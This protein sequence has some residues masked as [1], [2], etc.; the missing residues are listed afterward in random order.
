MLTY[1]IK[2]LGGP[3]MKRCISRPDLLA[4]KFDRSLCKQF[5]DDATQFER[6]VT[7]YG[8]RYDVPF[9]RT[10]CLTHELDFPAFGS[11]FHTDAYYAVRSKL[12]LHSN[13]LEAAC[14]ALGIPSKGHK[15][16]PMVWRDAGVGNKKALEHV[17]AHNVEDVES[18][19]ALWRRL[20][21]CFRA[22]KTS[23]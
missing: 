14:T 2:P 21:G 7:Y 17:L 3:V 4:G 5:L 9:L 16:S 12:K 11:V 19:E 8:S 15:L 1:C 18:L 22:T 10:R 6:I 13:R 23:I 20:T